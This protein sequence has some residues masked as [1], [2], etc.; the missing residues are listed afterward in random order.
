MAF[1]S[2]CGA[3]LNDDASFCNQCGAKN[4]ANEK[5]FKENATQVFDQVGESLSK[6][7]SKIKG[8]NDTADTTANY[9]KEDI[10]KNKII[11]I[12]AY[13]S[14]LVLIPM[15]LAKDSKFAKYHV[16]QGLILV[17]AGL[18]IAVLSLIAGII[19]PVIGIIFAI[20]EIPFIVLSVIGIVNVV[21]GKA[22]E[23]PVVG[24]FDFFN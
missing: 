16:K 9:D 12:F 6:G 2:K 17:I 14:I 23:L 7:V 1:C 8:L 20:F 3:Q 5:S 10:E 21:K 13:L 19:L 22:K 18:G 24:K 15:F 11:S 4:I